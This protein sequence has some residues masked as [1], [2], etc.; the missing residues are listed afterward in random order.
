MH[1]SMDGDL[2]RHTGNN[3]QMNGQLLRLTREERGIASS[4]DKKTFPQRTAATLANTTNGERQRTSQGRILLVGYSTTA[5][6]H[7]PA[8]FRNLQRS[9]SVHCNGSPLT[10]HTETGLW[11]RIAQCPGKIFQNEQAAT[12]STFGAARARRWP[13]GW[14]L[15][16]M[17]P[18]ILRSLLWKGPGALPTILQGTHELVRVGAAKSL[19]M[20]STMPS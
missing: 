3:K 9:S 4:K 19:A 13:H 5:V 1:N 16:V 6:S 7:Q 8:S 20:P 2:S 18:R 17:R 15:F 11:V 14:C 12:V 10:R